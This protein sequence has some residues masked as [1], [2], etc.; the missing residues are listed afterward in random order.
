MPNKQISLSSK[1][2][3]N[4]DVEESSKFVLSEINTDDKKPANTSIKWTQAS[5]Y[6]SNI[7]LEAA[8]Y[9][10]DVQQNH[11]WLSGYDSDSDDKY[12]CKVKEPVNFIFDHSNETKTEPTPSIDMLNPSLSCDE[13]EKPIFLSHSP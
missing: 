9:R 12:I 10:S 6:T 1:K 8:V 3:L 5:Y 4:E 11:G 7:Y 13:W 2:H